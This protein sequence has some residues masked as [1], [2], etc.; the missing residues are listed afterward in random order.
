MY[1]GVD[2]DRRMHVARETNNFDV[3]LAE[4]NHV[5]APRDG[6]VRGCVVQHPTLSQDF[7]NLCACQVYE[8]PIPQAI[9]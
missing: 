7:L 5:A 9:A 4:V 2:V 8:S 6:S 3:D 1:L